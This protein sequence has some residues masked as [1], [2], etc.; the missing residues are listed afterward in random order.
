M[1]TLVT[2]SGVF[3]ALVVEQAVVSEGDRWELAVVDLST[4][5]SRVMP[6]EPRD[7]AGTWSVSGL[8]M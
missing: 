2:S 8:G 4:G 7:I 1:A 6:L 5:A 3:G